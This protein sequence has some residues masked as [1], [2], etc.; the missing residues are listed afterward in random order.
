MRKSLYVVRSQG[1]TK[2]QVQCCKCGKIL[3]LRDVAE[4]T[5]KNDKTIAFMCMPCVKKQW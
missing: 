5:D 2:A 1:T 3:S 4:L